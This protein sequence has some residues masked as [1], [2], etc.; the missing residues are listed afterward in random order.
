M[1]LR[2]RVGGNITCTEE[3]CLTLQLTF[4][5]DEVAMYGSPQSVSLADWFCGVG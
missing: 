5:A 2:E 3:L 4:I 1:G